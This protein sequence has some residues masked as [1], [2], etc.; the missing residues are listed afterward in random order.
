MKPYFR[1]Q[2]LP[3]LNKD[4]WQIHHISN[5]EY[6]S[7]TENDI[8]SELDINTT[9]RS[10]LYPNKRINTSRLVLFMVYTLNNYA[11]T[12]IIQ[13]KC[14]C[15]DNFIWSYNT[16]L[17]SLRFFK[18]KMSLICNPDDTK[19]IIIYKNAKQQL[20]V[21]SFFKDKQV[22]LV[23]LLFKEKRQGHRCEKEI[24]FSIL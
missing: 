1:L 10:W 12:Q 15:S 2:I 24:H 14:E 22:H 11:E 8:Q 21:S 18:L 20:D 19:H 9:W 5:R 7:C 16:L 13:W 17:S 4:V 6:V 3:Q 23:I